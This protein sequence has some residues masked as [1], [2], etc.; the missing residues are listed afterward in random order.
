MA[1]LLCRGD[2][3]PYPTPPPPEMRG[4]PRIVV[5]YE[6]I[7]DHQDYK[8]KAIKAR[9]ASQLTYSDRTREEHWREIHHR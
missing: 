2:G 8:G 7:P 5:D 1:V 3:K 4:L 6:P 9:T